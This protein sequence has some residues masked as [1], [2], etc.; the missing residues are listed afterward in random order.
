M[1]GEILPLTTSIEPSLPEYHRSSLLQMPSR[2]PRPID[3]SL[4]LRSLRYQ[5]SERI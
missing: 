5:G 4:N 2:L 3:Q 1:P